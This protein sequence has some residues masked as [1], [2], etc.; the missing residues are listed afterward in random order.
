MKDS[1]KFNKLSNMNEIQLLA[2]TLKEH[3]NSSDYKKLET[4][5]E[6]ALERLPL[7]KHYRSRLRDAFLKV[8]AHYKSEKYFYE[9]AKALRKVL[10]VAPGNGGV[11]NDQ[12]K[13]FQFL[14]DNYGQEY[15][16][17]DFEY[18]EFVIQLFRLKYSK[19]K[20]SRKVHAQTEKA[21]FQIESM[22]VKAP[23]G[24]ESKHTF[25]IKQLIEP[26]TLGFTKEQ[27]KGIVETLSPIMPDLVREWKKIKEE[28]EKE[29]EKDKGKDK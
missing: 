8:A 7:T 15:I 26:F 17:N 27:R 9:Y 28:E 29:K 19:G 1:E 16:K 11:I 20:Y 24:A 22:K 6:V 4:T 3:V 21:L 23:G 5:V 2:Y 14:L 13:S 12:L 18:L 10:H 25:Q